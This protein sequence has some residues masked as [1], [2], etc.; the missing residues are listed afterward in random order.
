MGTGF[1]AFDEMIGNLDKVRLILVGG[2]PAMGKS[3]FAIS[4]AKNIAVEQK[5]S[6]LF[7][8][9]EMSSEQLLRRIVCN[10]CQLDGR[11]LLN[12]FLSEKEKA[13][14]E[15]EKENLIK[16]PLYID[17]TPGL[18]IQEFHSI[19]KNMVR[20]HDVKVVFIDYLQLMNADVKIDDHIKEVSLITKNLRRLADDLNITIVVCTQICRRKVRGWKKTCLVNLRMYGTMDKYADVVALIHRPEYYHLQN[21]ESKDQDKHGLAQIFIRKNCHGEKGYFFLKFD[22]GASRFYEPIIETD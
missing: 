12:G 13:L 6:S 22:S 16:F 19:V 20:E 8:S 2:R 17:D 14:F 5:I 3:A 9:L 18:S 10:I 4:L 21:S 15:T 11:R 7:F 1:K